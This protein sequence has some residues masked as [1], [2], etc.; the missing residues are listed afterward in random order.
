MPLLEMKPPPLGGGCSSRLVNLGVV[1]TQ[2]KKSQSNLHFAKSRS[3]KSAIVT[4]N[5]SKF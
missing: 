4:G 3:V 5:P 2:P 1:A